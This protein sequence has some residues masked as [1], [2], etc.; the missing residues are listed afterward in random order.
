LGVVVG[1][2][3]DF[4]DGFSR[5]DRRFALKLGDVELTGGFG[6]RNVWIYWA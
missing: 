5:I 4:L 3:G 2:L 1:P 6:Q